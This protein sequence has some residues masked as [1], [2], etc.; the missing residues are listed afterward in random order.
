MR[1]E[2]AI[3]VYNR[4]N[5]TLQ[6]TLE[7]LSMLNAMVKTAEVFNDYETIQTE[8]VKLEKEKNHLIQEMSKAQR[9]I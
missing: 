6:E 8:I 2:T 9:S 4:L 5:N 1:K 7:V 3:K